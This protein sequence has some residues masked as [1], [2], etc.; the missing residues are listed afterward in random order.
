MYHDVPQGRQADGLEDGWSEDAVRSW[1]FVGVRVLRRGAISG[2]AYFELCVYYGKLCVQIELQVVSPSGLGFKF[3]SSCKVF[4]GSSCRS[5]RL[6]VRASTNNAKHQR[7][8]AYCGLR[9]AIA[10]CLP[11]LA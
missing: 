10:I 4:S 7:I 3:W 1:R 2:A 6:L 8:S 9:P 5:A 11:N